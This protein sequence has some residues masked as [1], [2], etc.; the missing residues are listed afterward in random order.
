M[1]EIQKFAKEI[2]HI[3]T[4]DI[5]SEIFS[6]RNDL[7]KC[8]DECEDSLLEKLQKLS[9]RNHN[10]IMSDRLPDTSIFEEKAK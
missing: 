7:N 1:K 8:R 3:P 2:K 6:N 9:S 4:E 10:D 5:R